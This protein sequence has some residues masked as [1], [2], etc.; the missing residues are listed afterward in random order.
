MSSLSVLPG[1][2]Q[3]LVL[4]AMRLLTLDGCAP[5][6]EAAPR[7]RVLR[8]QTLLRMRA[9]L[10]AVLCLPPLLP[11]Y[12][13]GAAEIDTLHPARAWDEHEYQSRAAH[14]PVLLRAVARS[15]GPA[16]VALRLGAYDGAGAE[17]VLPD[18][19][20]WCARLRELAFDDDG[21]VDERL[22]AQLSASRVQLL[23]VNRPGTCVLRAVR[24]GMGSLRE[25]R[26]E[27]VD[28]AMARELRD[29]LA[30]G[31]LA[32]VTVLDV[33]FATGCCD[34]RDSDADDDEDGGETVATC[35]QLGARLNEWVPRLRA[36]RV[37]LGGCTTGE[38]AGTRTAGS[39]RDVRDVLNVGER[40]VASRARATVDKRDEMKTG[41]RRVE[42]QATSIRRLQQL[43]AMF[44]EACV[45]AHVA[46][47]VD[48]LG[49][50]VGVEG[51]ANVVGVRR[52]E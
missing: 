46:L 42:L 36:L 19:F 39:R 1:D 37:G 17:T 28:G 45:R 22:C 7:P 40:V 13:A 41:P 24:E 51:T 2:I 27:Q 29:T 14:S 20:Q 25:V 11:H 49:V 3:A 21:R 30:C 38:G 44:G 32:L 31:A 52:A 12:A 33:V 34:A 18:V 35:A 10:P 48:G 15:C 5:E 47:D 8:Q 50:E 4:D 6:R 23:R 16:L 26:L 9:L 43:H